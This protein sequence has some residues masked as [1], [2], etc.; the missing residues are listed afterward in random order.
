MRRITW[1]LILFLTLLAAN[2]LGAQVGDIMHR[3]SATLASSRVFT[4]FSNWGVISQPTDSRPHGAWMAPTNGYLGDVSLLVGLELPIHDYNGDSLPDTVHSVITC[5]VSRPSMDTDTDPF[6]GQPLTFEPDTGYVSPTNESVALS[7][8]PTTWPPSWPD[9]PEYGQ[10]VWNGLFGENTFAGDHETYFRISDNNDRRFNFPWLNAQ[11]IVFHPDSNDLS[12]TGQGISIGVRYILSDSLPFRDV[13][14]RVFDITNTSTWR[15]ERVVLGTLCGTYV[16]ITGS[17]NTSQEWD[18]DIS[19][20]YKSTNEILTWDFDNNA[21]RNPSWVGGVGRFGESFLEVPA[22]PA[23][24]SYYGFQPAGMVQ[25]GNDEWLW[26]VM[27]PGSFFN[28]PVVVNDTIPLAGGDVDYLYG[29]DYFSL[30]PGQTRRVASVIAYGM[31]REEVEFNILKAAMLWNSKFDQTATLGGVRFTGFASHRVFR[32]ITPVEWSTSTPGSSVD[33]WYRPDVRSAWVSIASNVP[34][35]G[36]F[37]W[38]T[39]SF[40]DGAFGTLRIALRD[41]AD[42]PI[43]FAESGSTF[44]VDN[45]GNSP[46][47]LLMMNNELSGGNIV[48]DSTYPISLLTGDPED[49]LLAITGYYRTVSSGPWTP[50]DEFSVRMLP[51]PQERVV[52]LARLPNSDSFQLKFTVSDGVFLRGDSSGIFQKRTPRVSNIESRVTHVAGPADVPLEVHVVRPDL[53]RSDT[54][55]V[56]F[57]DT[58]TLGETTFS[59]YD[60]STDSYPLKSAPLLARQESQYFDG[61][62][63]YTNN[64]LTAYDP[65]RSS[66]NR[67]PNPDWTATMKPVDYQDLSLNGYAQPDDYDIAFDTI[68]IDTSIALPP[69]LP[70]ILINCRVTSHTTGAKVPVTAVASPG[71]VELLFWEKPGGRLRPTWDVSLYFKSTDA[72]PVR[73]DTLKLVTTKAFSFLDTVRVSTVVVSVERQKRMPLSFAL[74]QSFPNPCNPSAQI[75]YTVPVTGR[76][77]IELFNLLGEKVMELAKGEVS[78]GTHEVLMDGSHLPSGV[79]FYRLKAGSFVNT[80]KLLLLR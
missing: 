48:P 76:I 37:E 63:L 46:P 64:I 7:D 68:P 67:L 69:D 70:A 39:L 57:D 33:L 49:S 17:D 28:P 16:G 65:S 9:H 52:N 24:A 22:T 61:L 62:A 14:F 4:V 38:N 58:T 3:R 23:I 36:I 5:S 27:K 71:Y 77:V 34:N 53:V 12:R 31:T 18:D 66:W 35:T 30:D 72:V 42:R 73:G 60:Q 75:R 45:P 15:Y 55:I 47:I 51:Q 74:D 20:F 50:F 8:D 13:L 79:Y 54:Y 41:S 2:N 56:T 44:T 80:K 25:L 59:V 6:T 29:S 1:F 10:S 43:A 26:N 21:S 11:G 40:S 19:V 78:A 32:G